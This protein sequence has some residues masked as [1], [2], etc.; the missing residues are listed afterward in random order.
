MPKR[1]GFER[2]RRELSLGVSVGVHILLVVEQ[3]SLESQS[4][5]CAKTP[6]LTVYT[7]VCIYSVAQKHLFVFIVCMSLFMADGPQRARLPVPPTVFQRYHLVNTCGHEGSSHLS[8]V[9]SLRISIAKKVQQSYNSSN[10]G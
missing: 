9:L 6:I 5:G 3:S 1:A 10:N 2:S 8:P 7:E 4:R